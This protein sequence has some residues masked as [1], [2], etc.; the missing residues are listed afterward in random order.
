M[1]NQRIAMVGCALLAALALTGCGGGGADSD[2][3]SG[4]VV[5]SLEGADIT[6]DELM[7]RLTEEQ[8]DLLQATLDT[9]AAEIVVKREAESRDLTE[10]DLFTQEVVSQISL[11][12]TTQ[13][14][15]FYDSGKDTTFKGQTFE[16]AR[17]PISEFLQRQKLIDRRNEFVG[18]LKKDAGFTIRLEPPRVAIDLPPGTP[19]KGGTDAPITIV[20]FADFECPACRRAYPDIERLLL[21]FSGQIQF[22]F[23]DFPLTT[24][25]PRAVPASEAAL[26]ANEQGRFWD[27]HQNLML[28]TGNLDDA[29]LAKRAAD[30]QLDVAK[31]AECYQSRRH[32]GVVRSSFQL[33]REKGVD[34][35]PTFFVNGRKIVGAPAYDVFRE[36]IETELARSSENVGG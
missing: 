20:E 10:E 13:I 25:H 34:S 33:G 3:A 30:L 24:L 2:G 31:F 35:T 22:A 18:G 16:Q 7:A 1:K 27:Y 19:M 11:P 15:Q 21:E 26:C 36:I 5:A 23:V 17:G 29:D 6:S 8:F 32:S 4:E 14:Q 28:L 12:D 9:M